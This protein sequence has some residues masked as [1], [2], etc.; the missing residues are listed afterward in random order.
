LKRKARIDREC[1][2]LGTLEPGLSQTQRGEA[3]QGKVT[4][5]D[6]SSKKKRCEEFHVEMLTDLS[7]VV[8]PFALPGM[9]TPQI[10]QIVF[11]KT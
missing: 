5:A 4:T 11:E 7:R 9:T 1:G 2:A 3:K 8:R 10:F 6:S